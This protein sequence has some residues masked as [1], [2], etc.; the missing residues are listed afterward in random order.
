MAAVLPMIIRCASPEVLVLEV[1]LPV[2][3][4]LAEALELEVLVVLVPFKRIAL[5]YE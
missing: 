2:L 1:L 4:W 5:R 3:V